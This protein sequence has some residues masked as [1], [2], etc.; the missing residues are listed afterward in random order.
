MIE[1]FE[2][3]G[4]R[5]VTVDVMA[6]WLLARMD[7]IVKRDW[8]IAFAYDLDWLHSVINATA[9]QW[10]RK[11]EPRPVPCSGCGLLALMWRPPY[12]EC[13]ARLGGCSR[14]YL[15]SEYDDLVA[16]WVVWTQGQ[17]EVAV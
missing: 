9:P 15:A 12:V 2:L 14:L 7:E 10:P 4:P 3:A 11:E 6:A 16:Q 13:D 1:D 5:R 8:V 17:Q